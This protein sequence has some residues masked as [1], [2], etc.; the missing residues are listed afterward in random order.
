MTASSRPLAIFAVRSVHGALSLFFLSCLAYIYYAVVTRK[1]SRLLWFAIGALLLEGA[2]VSVNNGDCPLGTVHRR[3][4]D[5]KTFFELF[6][7][8]RMADRAVPFF[9]AVA[10]LG[11][12]LLLVRRPAGPGRRSGPSADRPRVHGAE[13]GAA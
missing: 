6:V 2:V 11:L 5:D 10:V 7:P 1:R 12:A 4:G 3:Y 8:R 9:T 13:N